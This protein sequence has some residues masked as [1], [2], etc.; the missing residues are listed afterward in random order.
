M[1]S[2]V[3]VNALVGET[4]AVA[5]KALEVITS[6]VPAAALMVSLWVPDVRPV[7]A[8]VIVGDPDLLSP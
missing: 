3:V 5:L 4:L 6:L 1:S 2:S 7:P 8:A